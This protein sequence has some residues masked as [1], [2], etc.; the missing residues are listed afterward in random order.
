MP[1]HQESDRK[2]YIPQTLF[3]SIAATFML[4]LL[5]CS[6]TDDLAGAKYDQGV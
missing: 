4:L 2:Y 6:G 3:T 1:K 5:S